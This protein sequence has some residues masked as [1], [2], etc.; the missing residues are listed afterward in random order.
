M[1]NA[2]TGLLVLDLLGGGMR[3]S[4]AD[5]PWS[6]LVGVA[7]VSFHHFYRYP[8]TRTLLYFFLN[9]QAP[10]ALPIVLA[11]VSAIGGFFAIGYGISE[12]LRPQPWGPPAVLLASALIMLVRDPTARDGYNRVQG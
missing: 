7:Y 4:L 5:L 8:R 1:H 10:A 2:N 11:L 9:W 3:V 12:Y 6:L